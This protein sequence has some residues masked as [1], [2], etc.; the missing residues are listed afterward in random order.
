M[1]IKCCNSIS[2][3]QSVLADISMCCVVK[4]EDKDVGYCWSTSANPPPLMA[5][6]L[7]QLLKNEV[8]AVT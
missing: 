3:Q 1:C 7:K 5:D 2:Y 8:S 6:N 4:M